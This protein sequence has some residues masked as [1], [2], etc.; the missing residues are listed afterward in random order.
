MVQWLRLQVP[1]AGGLSLIP[2]WGIRSHSLHLRVHMLQ[3]NIPQAATKS[4]GS[5]KTN[6]CKI[7]RKTR[8]HRLTRVSPNG[9]GCYCNTLSSFLKQVLAGRGRVSSVVLLVAQSC[10]TLC[11]RMDCSPPGSS[12]H[13]ILQARILEWVAISFCRGSSR[14][15]DLTPVSC[16]VGRFFTI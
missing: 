4:Q 5:H 13:G 9:K 11:D 3:Q 7:P 8:K 1:S 2:G 6:N 16:I 15:R 10:L 12:V 14:S